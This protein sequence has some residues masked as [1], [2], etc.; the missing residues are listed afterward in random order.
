MEDEA[1]MGKEQ[2]APLRFISE[3]AST[4]LSSIVEVQECDATEV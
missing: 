1:L 2:K 3:G 4:M